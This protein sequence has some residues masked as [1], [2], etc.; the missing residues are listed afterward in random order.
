M[1]RATPIA[2]LALL[3]CVPLI[4]AA[5]AWAT[6]TFTITASFAPDRLGV[7][8]NLSAKATFAYGSGAPVPI[9]NF[10]AYGPAGLRLDLTGTQDCSKAALENEGP[11]ACPADSRIGFGG[12]TALVEAAG[13]TIKEPFTFELFLAASEQARSAMLV[14]V[15]AIKPVSLQ[16]VLIAREIQGS[17]PYGLGVR[18]EVPPIDTV[19]GAALASVADIYLTIGSQRVAY[20]REIHGHRRLQH[21][22]GL[23]L[24]SSCP[25]GGF[26][27]LI[28]TRFADGV[29][30]TDNR[31]VPCP[32][33]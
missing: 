20:Y 11:S 3:L 1:R 14:Y 22:K 4:A 16:N 5:V 8:T 6:D 30:L 19:P 15:D 25:D 2:V 33:K 7:P 21:I 10:R 12:G 17:R 26:P 13:E 9:S 29:S 18:I 23:V 32:G 28:S 27:L 31:T 24:P